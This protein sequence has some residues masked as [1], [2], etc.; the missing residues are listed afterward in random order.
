LNDEDNTFLEV[1]FVNDL[2]AE[3]Q[4]RKPKSA[5]SASRVRYEKYTGARAL[6]EAKTKGATWDD[7]KWDFSRGYIDFKHT[8]GYVDLGECWRRRV[9]GGIGLSPAAA[10]DEFSNVVYTGQFG[11]LTLD[12]ST[13]RT[14]R[15]C[16]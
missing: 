15:S 3:Y 16:R 7:I 4:Q 9:G 11:A 10:V 13:N 2:P 14:P 1:A 12:E 8:A 5:T 6:R